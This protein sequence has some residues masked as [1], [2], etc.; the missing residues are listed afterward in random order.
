MVLSYQPFI[1]YI[2]MSRTNNK[3]LSGALC[4]STQHVCSFVTAD[5]LHL[6][7]VHVFRYVSV[8]IHVCEVIRL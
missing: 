2:K 1:R 3:P 4:A 7:A 5:M 6:D 8:H